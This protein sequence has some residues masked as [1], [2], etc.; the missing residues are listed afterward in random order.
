MM[1]ETEVQKHQR[2]MRELRDA[3]VKRLRKQGVE[4]TNWTPTKSFFW[5]NG[6]V[7]RTYDGK[8]SWESKYSPLIVDIEA[9]Y[10]TE[11]RRIHVRVYNTVQCFEDFKEHDICEF[12]EQL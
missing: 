9:T 5:G 1:T 10:H 11:E 8:Y 3:M 4:I 12:E 6:R 7:D 2:I